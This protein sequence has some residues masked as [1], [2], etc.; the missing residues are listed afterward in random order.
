MLAPCTPLYLQV[1]ERTLLTTTLV[2]FHGPIHSSYILTSIATVVGGGTAGIT[3]ASRLA[4]D[5]TV[6]VAIIEAGGF[7]ETDNGNYSVI[8]GLSLSS[9]F[10]STTVPYQ[11]QPLV[12]WNL[13]S[14][15]QTGASGRR[16][17]YAQGKT[18][19]GTSGINALAYHRASS[20]TYQRWADLVG[21]QSYTFP[22]L[23]PYFKKSCHLTPPNFAKR[24][25]PNATVEFDTTAFDKNGG[26]LEVSWSNWVDTPLTWFQKAFALIGLPVSSENFMS[27]SIIQKSAWIPSTISPSDAVRSSSQSSF[28]TRALNTT[29]ITVYTHTQAKKILFN[30]KRPSPR[31][32]GVSVT[33]GGKNYMISAKK[34][35]I[36]SAGVFHSPQ[37]LMVSGIVPANKRKKRK[38]PSADSAAGIGPRATLEKYN[39]SVISDLAGVGQNL[40]DQILFP[41]SQVMNIPTAAQLITEPQFAAATKQKYIQDAAGPLSA[42]NAFVAFEKIP[43]PLRNN[44]TKTALSTL[45]SL[46]HDWPEVMYVTGSNLGP[47]N[48]GLG[49]LLVAL[50]GSFSRGT[51][52]LSSAD[53]ASPPVINL[54]W[55]TDPANVDAQ[56]A[57]AALKR[58]RQAWSSIPNITIG[59]ELAPGPSVQSDQAILAYIRNATTTLYHGAGTCAMGKRGDGNAVVD[60]SARVF[61]VKGLRV[62]D[63]SAAPF[64]VPGNPQSTIYMLAEKI[65]HL[66]RTG[67]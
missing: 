57:V 28:L 21:D 27:G 31:A 47:N 29:K 54:G 5:P 61:G 3:V 22:S 45:A 11:Q 36:L 33:S 38:K 62:V 16:I 26:P 40:W 2:G 17:H 24:G 4:E 1:L 12:D 55:L 65:A 63:Y 41:V 25:T 20:G 67:G 32:V 56:V 66:I 60:S 13:V 64:A 15:P 42:T 6:S 19:G 9:P 34:E 7:Y 18:L 35:V 53:M 58:M 10:L 30:S 44:F 50:S 49:L 51:V 37:L 14:V 52:T 59:P 43:S 48:S 23:L 39:I 46:P 8:P